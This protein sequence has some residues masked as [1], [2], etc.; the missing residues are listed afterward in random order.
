M[1]INVDS[2]FIGGALLIVAIAIAALAIVIYGNRDK[3]E[4][5]ETEP[6][7]ELQ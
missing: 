7:E 4:P 6:S 3:E 1:I 5:V 2:L